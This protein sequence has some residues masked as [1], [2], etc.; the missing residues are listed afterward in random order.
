MKFITARELR[1]ASANLWDILPEEKEIV[2][3]LNGKPV[4]LIT[5]ISDT[6]FDASLREIRRAKAITAMSGMHKD[7]EKC[8]ASKLTMEEIDA[9]IKATRKSRKP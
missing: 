5:P 7:A 1:G 8:G 3:T 2:V 4:A 6:N 9:E